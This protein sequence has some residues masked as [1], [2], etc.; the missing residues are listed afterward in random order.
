VQLAALHQGTGATAAAK[1]K[2]D[3]GEGLRPP[4]GDFVSAAIA[5]MGFE[6]ED[7]AKKEEDEEEAE[8]ARKK[9]KKKGFFGFGGKR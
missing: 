5:A 4:L 2:A 3:G 9:K 8:E 6:S 7:D 1:A